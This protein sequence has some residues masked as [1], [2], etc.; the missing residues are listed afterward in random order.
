[1]G[2]GYKIKK[3]YSRYIMK[4]TNFMYFDPD[5]GFWPNLDP[6]PGLCY[7]VQKKMLNNF[8]EKTIFKNLFF[9]L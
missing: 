1:M 8:R 7:Q 6:G 9:K 4:N 5:P 3:C 2:K